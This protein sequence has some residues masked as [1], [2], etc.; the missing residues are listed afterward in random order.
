MKS[1]E[2][3]PIKNDKITGKLFYSI[4]IARIQILSEKPCIL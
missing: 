1:L 4:T 2:I 3:I